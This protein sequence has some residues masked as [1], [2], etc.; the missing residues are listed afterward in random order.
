MVPF[1]EQYGELILPPCFEDKLIF[2]NTE[3]T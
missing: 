2:E 3:F 1:F